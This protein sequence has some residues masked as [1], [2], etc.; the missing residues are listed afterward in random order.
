[1]TQ[2]ETY[3]DLARLEQ[4]LDEYYR[5]AS[6]DP[7]KLPY[8]TQ[9]IWSLVTKNNLDRDLKVERCPEAEEFDGFLQEIDGYLCELGDAQ[10]R[11]GLHIFGE[12]PQGEQR[13][14][15]IQAMMRLDNGEVPSL[16]EGRSRASFGFDP[17]PSRRRARARRS[18]DAV[19]GTIPRRRETA[20]ERHDAREALD[21]RRP[22]RGMST[23]L[24]TLSGIK[25]SSSETIRLVEMTDGFR[26]DLRDV[27]PCSATSFATRSSPAST[28]PPTS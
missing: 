12:P 17:G 21:P 9:Q 19:T 2:A 28:A 1:M 5:M 16:R 22:G 23:E 15:L 25:T 18:S 8:I 3:D 10:I 11:D 20:R 4:L 7:T 13:V 14:E 27:R 6:L 26:S 24:P